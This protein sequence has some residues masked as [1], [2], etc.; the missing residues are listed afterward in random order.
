MTTNTS[1]DAAHDRVGLSSHGLPARVKGMNRELIPLDRVRGWLFDLDG[2]LMDTDDQSILSLA[3]RLHFLEASRAQEFARRVV[4]FSETPSNSLL[5]LLDILHLDTL[6]FAMERR[7]RHA[8]H[9]YDFKLIEGVK[10]V[11][12][13]LAALYPLAIVSTRSAA[14]AQAFLIQHDLENLFTAIVTRESTHRLKPHP[15]PVLLA[16]KMLNLAPELVIMVGDTTVDMRS[17]RRAGAW[18]VGVL[19]G[20]GREHELWRAGAHAV[21]PSTADLLS[22][23]ELWAADDA[24]TGRPHTEKSEA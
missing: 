13:K 6:A 24:G 9:G 17:A 5:T 4:M 14:A 7:L 23:E 18:A 16:A 12:I 22:S 1:D 15:A 3:R 8:E 11:L 20:F 10:P 2:T 19:C 21:L